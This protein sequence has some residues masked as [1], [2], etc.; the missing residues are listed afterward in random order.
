MK[1]TSPKNDKKKKDD[2]DEEKE[3]KTKLKEAL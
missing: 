1:V 3:R 2:T